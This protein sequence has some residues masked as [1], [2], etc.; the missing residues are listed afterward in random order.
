MTP[1]LIGSVCYRI[2]LDEYLRI[3]NKF[4]YFIDLGWNKCDSKFRSAMISNSKTIKYSISDSTV[5]YI[6]F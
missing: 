3:P 4:V 2:S 6:L 1:S 5:D